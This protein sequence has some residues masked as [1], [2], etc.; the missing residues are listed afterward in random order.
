MRRR[1]ALE[2]AHVT[3]LLLALL[4]S[5]CG[6]YRV[7]FQPVGGL[8]EIAVPIFEN[9]TLRRRYEYILTQHVRERILDQT[10]MQLGREGSAPAI[11][12]G[13]IVSVN[14]GVLIPNTVDTAPPLESSI[15]ITVAV[16]LV[17]RQSGHLIVGGASPHGDDRPTGPAYL[18]E[19]ESYVEG[20]NQTAD[21]AADLALKKL[22]ERIVDLLEQGW[23]GAQER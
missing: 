16:S 6:V 2:K 9:K 5:G 22:A 19:T 21:T 18:T 23:G 4:G 13:V 14:Q 11:L 15:T 8:Q 1:P 7:G 10:P 3:L 20:L 17:D 12:R